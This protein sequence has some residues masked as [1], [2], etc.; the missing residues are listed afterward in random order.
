MAEA[1]MLEGDL[2]PLGAFKRESAARRMRMG[3]R[4]RRL[5]GALHGPGQHH[6][7]AST[8]AAESRQMT[9]EVWHPLQMRELA[10]VDHNATPRR[11]PSHNTIVTTDSQRPPPRRYIQARAGGTGRCR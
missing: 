1:Q 6:L 7:A 9:V 4:F 8:G 2:A 3:P 10:T 5:D 11:A